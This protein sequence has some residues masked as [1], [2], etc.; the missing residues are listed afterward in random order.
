VNI[1]INSTININLTVSLDSY[2]GE[3]FVEDIFTTAFYGGVDY[4]ALVEGVIG[5][6]EGYT[7][8]DVNDDGARY[9]VNYDT[10]RLGLKRI[11][12]ARA[13]FYAPNASTPEG[14]TQCA[15]VKNLTAHEHGD[16]VSALRELDAGDIDA[17][18]ADIIV[19]AGVFGELK[20]S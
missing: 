5:E 7:I 6:Y 8:T 4:W 17:H 9:V 18:L 13:P 20:Y 16:V 12:E 11:A 14:R 19:Q 15:D 10:V 1:N 2:E 3:G